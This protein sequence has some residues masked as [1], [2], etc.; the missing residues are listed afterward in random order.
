MSVE[1]DNTGTKNIKWTAPSGAVGLTQKTVML[2]Y[3]QIAAPAIFGQLWMVYD[4][5]GTDADEFS[6]I[7]IPAVASLKIGYATHFS[8]TD[9][10]WVATNNVLTNGAMHHIAVTY[11]GALTT[12][13]PT[14]YVNGSSI[15]ITETSTPV[16]TFRSGTNTDMYLASAISGNNPNGRLNSLLVYNRILSASEIADAYAS[17]LSIPSY[18]G[19]VFAPDLCRGESVSAFDGAVLGSSNTLRDIITG[20]AGTPS[21]SPI[22]RGDAY[23]THQ[24]VY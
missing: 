2:W 16:G 10:I 23:L 8:T 14:I 4:G 21:G 18:Q 11:D 7:Q 5:I 24:G 1:F 13:D 3:Y 19:L 6:Y 15:A 20:A 12:N 9:G 22:G 17:K